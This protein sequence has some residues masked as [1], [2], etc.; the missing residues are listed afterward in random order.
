MP[1]TAPTSAIS[2]ASMASTARIR[3]RVSPTA[4]STAFSLVR[5]TT[6]RLSVFATPTR[7]ITTARPSSAVTR[8]SSMSTVPVSIFL[9]APWSIRFTVG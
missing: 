2:T 8:A 5:S 6:D 7:A 1:S 9:Y 4:R 3:P